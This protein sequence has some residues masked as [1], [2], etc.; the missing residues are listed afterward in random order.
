MDSGT[1]EPVNSVNITFS[2]VNR[3]RETYTLITLCE[4]EIY[5]EPATQCPLGRYG[6]EC[7]LA[8][9]CSQPS[10]P[11][12]VS[13]GM[14]ASGCP[15][16]Y[17]GEGCWTAYNYLRTRIIINP[18]NATTISTEMVGQSV[19]RVLQEKLWDEE[20][21][22]G[23]NIFNISQGNDSTI[24]VSVV[25][26]LNQ[27][28]TP[29]IELKIEIETDLKAIS[30]DGVVYPVN[31]GVSRDKT[32]QS[33]GSEIPVLILTG[34]VSA[35]FVLAVLIVVVV[36]ICWRKAKIDRN[37]PVED[38]ADS[39]A[40][41]ENYDAHRPEPDNGDLAVDEGGY[42]EPVVR[43]VSAPRPADGCHENSS[44]PY[45]EIVEPR[46]GYELLDIRTTDRASGRLYWAINERPGEDATCTVPPRRPLPPIVDTNSDDERP[47]SDTY[48]P[49]ED[50]RDDIDTRRP[51]EE[52]N[53][54]DLNNYVQ[55]LDEPVSNLHSSV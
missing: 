51:E 21:V 17:M 43:P 25:I 29:E 47:V 22:I 30:I 5:G 36:I 41:S 26:V 12:Y 48:V 40:V 11:C 2:K 53:A 6:R 39:P 33:R 54:E 20:T 49:L 23:V 27:P 3:C 50:V 4:V 8:C 38:S 1:S 31:V 44:N 7:E 32:P 19:K 55:L 13:T 16:G 18:D 37:I 24:V 14:C 52:E 46:V 9:Q 45:Y 10:E 42:L 35:A 28:V 34:G 15:V